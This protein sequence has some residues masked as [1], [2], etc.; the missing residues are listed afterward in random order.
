MEQE[1]KRINLG[2]VILPFFVYFI[3]SYVAQF[4]CTMIVAMSHVGELLQTAPMNS[5]MNNDE[6]LQA[7]AEITVALME[8]IEPYQVHI[9]G[10]TAICVMLVTY[11]AFYQRDRK[12]EAFLGILPDSNRPLNFFWAAIFGFSLCLGTN[13]LNI[14][15]TLAFD[16]TAYMDASAAV[17][18]AAFPIQVLVLG[19]ITP[20][21]E[22]LM[23]R[24][25]IFKRLREKYNFKFAMVMSSLVFAVTHG[26]VVQVYY[27]LILGMFLC[28]IYEKYQTI[29]APII[30]H[31]TANMLSVCGTNAGYFEKMAKS[32]ALMAVL[33]VCSVFFGAV[34]YMRIRTMGEKMENITK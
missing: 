23:F 33:F 24:G 21:S 10:G 2:G 26:S 22:E 14:M 11:F 19:F 9:L 15:M 25:V 18:A 3:V 31:I 16:N 30:V 8:L 29:K 13:C 20:V 27:T 32:P 4:L 28:Y 6:L 17:Y 34:M 7:Y 1:Q 5:A 12:K